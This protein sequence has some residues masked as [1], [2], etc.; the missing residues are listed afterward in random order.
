MAALPWQMDVGRRHRVVLAAGCSLRTESWADWS[1][2][3]RSLGDTVKAGSTGRKPWSVKWAA[4]GLQVVRTGEGGTGQWRH[5][6]Q[7]ADERWLM[8]PGHTTWAAAVVAGP[9][10]SQQWK[11]SAQGPAGMQRGVR[12]CC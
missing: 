5:R 6:I 12:C 7:I 9:G 8:V 2:R 10:T 3:N 4:A 1:R 11:A